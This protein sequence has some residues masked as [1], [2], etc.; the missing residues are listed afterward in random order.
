[1]GQFGAD[2]A[3]PGLDIDPPDLEIGDDGKPVQTSRG[4][5]KNEDGREG[6]GGWIGRMVSRTRNHE[7]DDGNRGQY[8]RI[9]DDD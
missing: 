9:R 5:S 7:Q 3:I 6:L 8:G 4:R 1:M 2:A